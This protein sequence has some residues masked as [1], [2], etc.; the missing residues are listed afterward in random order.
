MGRFFGKMW[1]STASFT[2]T[3]YLVTASAMAGTGHAAAVDTAPPT[4][5]SANY[6]GSEMAW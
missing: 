3:L 4:S 1:G 6:A 5:S 2:L